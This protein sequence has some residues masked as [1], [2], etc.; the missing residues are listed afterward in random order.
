MKPGHLNRI[1]LAT[2]T[3]PPAGLLLLWRDRE[4]R[5]GR[6][7]FGTVGILLY[8]IVYAAGIVAL[9]MR[10]GGLQMEWQGGFPPVLTFQKTVPNYDALEA[11]RAKQTATKPAKPA[12]TSFTSV[13]W[14]GFRGPK[15]D[16]ID[17]EKQL[18]VP[19]DPS[20]PPLLWRQ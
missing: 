7:V 10:F 11:H 4:I 15:R 2:Y 1:R 13:Y 16:G 18:H 8:S 3:F 20:G 5:L 6:K 12:P 9:F 19:W 17:S 14:T